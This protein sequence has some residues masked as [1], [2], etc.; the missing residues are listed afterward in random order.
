[1]NAGSVSTKLD[2]WDSIEIRIHK[3]VEY[4][5]KL[6]KD[7]DK[8]TIFVVDPMLATGGSA[9]DAID[10]IKQRGGKEIIFMCLIAAPKRIEALK[11]STPGR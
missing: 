2:M 1:M 3:P 11:E 4:Y 6:P 9:I 10:S 7:I 5:C 8:R